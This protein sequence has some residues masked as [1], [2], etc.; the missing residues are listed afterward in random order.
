VTLLKL[1]SWNEGIF[2]LREALW[3]DPGNADLKKEL[4]DALAQARAHGIAISPP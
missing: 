1:G 3:R 2:Q 4:E